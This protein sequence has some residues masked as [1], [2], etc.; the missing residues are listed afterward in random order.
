[1]SSLSL[2]PCQEFAETYEI[3]KQRIRA[4]ING[5]VASGGP[6]I[7]FTSCKTGEG[8]SSI[9]AN[10]AAASTDGGER[11]VLLMDCNLQKPSLNQFLEFGSKGRKTTQHTEKTEKAESFE[12]VWKVVHTNQNLDILVTQKITSSSAT[13]FSR[14]WFTDLLAEAHTQYDLIV[15]DCPPLLED[16]SVAFLATRAHG[17]VLVVEAE[18]IRREVIQKSINLLEESGARILGVVLNKRKFPI[19]QCIYRL[20]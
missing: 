16:G 12:S 14:G 1:M 4:L 3:L 20:L 8:V 2:K 10:F 7:A 11:R 15:L 19:P 18:R 9:A 6:I 17:V 5:N 13:I